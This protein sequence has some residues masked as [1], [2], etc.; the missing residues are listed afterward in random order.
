MQRLERRNRGVDCNPSLIQYLERRN[1]VS[2]HSRLKDEA[3]DC[4]SAARSTRQ[5]PTFAF[6]NLLSYNIIHQAVSNVLSYIVLSY[7]ASLLDAGLSYSN[8]VV[9]TQPHYRPSII[10]AIK[11]TG[12]ERVFMVQDL[13][14]LV[15]FPVLPRGEPNLRHPMTI[16]VAEEATL[17][18]LWNAFAI[19]KRLLD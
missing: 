15:P 7:I 8:G 1:A 18:N 13:I 16:V 5:I 12:N 4:A 9:P 6:S 2:L 17:L 14:N 19:L 11:T 3:G 10:R